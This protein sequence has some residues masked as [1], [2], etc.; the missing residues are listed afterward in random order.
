MMR[1]GWLLVGVFLGLAGAVHFSQA[2][3]APAGREAAKTPKSRIQDEG[4]REAVSHMIDDV[5]H[6]DDIPETPIKQAFEH[7]LEG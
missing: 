6:R 3:E 4:A 1:M 7:A 2:Q 5:A